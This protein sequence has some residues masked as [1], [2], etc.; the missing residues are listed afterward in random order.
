MKDNVNR[1]RFDLGAVIGP[2]VHRVASR[3]PLCEPLGAAL[4]AA[5]LGSVLF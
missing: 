2:A 3:V 1:T 5:P 4:L